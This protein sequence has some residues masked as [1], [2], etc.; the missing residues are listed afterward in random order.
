MT[1]APEQSAICR[2]RGTSPSLVMGIPHCNDAD[3]YSPIAHYCTRR[4][5]KKAS[6][7]TESPSPAGKICA[8]PSVFALR[9]TE[10]SFCGTDLGRRL[11][12]PTPALLLSSDGKIIFGTTWACASPPPP[13]FVLALRPRPLPNGKQNLVPTWASASPVTPSGCRPFDRW[14]VA[15]P[16]GSRD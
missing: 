4:G 11:P 1:T 9:G 15:S 14:N 8:D 5:R 10:K 16:T 2:A 7:P 6:G 3:S 12:F 13:P